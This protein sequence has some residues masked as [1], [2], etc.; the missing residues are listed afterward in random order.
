MEDEYE[1]TTTEGP[2]TAKVIQGSSDNSIQDAIQDALT[3]NPKTSNHRFLVLESIAVEEGGFVGG[4]IYHV[5]LNPQP[6]PPGPEENHV[7]LNPQPLPPGPE[8]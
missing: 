7:E 6:L 8:E 1:G 2:P 5:A 3:R 4:T